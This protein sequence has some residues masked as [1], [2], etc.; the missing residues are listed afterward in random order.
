[1]TGLIKELSKTLTELKE[2]ENLPKDNCRN[3]SPCPPQEDHCGGENKSQP[4]VS[5]HTDPEQV[6]R[7]N[8]SPKAY[9]EGP[10]EGIIDP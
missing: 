2:R 3:S 5:K 4:I 10:S 7:Q 9:P 1:M 6:P 8:P